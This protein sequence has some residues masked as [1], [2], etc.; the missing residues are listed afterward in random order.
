MAGLAHNRVESPLKFK[1]FLEDV[2]TLNQRA[3]QQVF[4]ITKLSFMALG[5]VRETYALL[6]S[7]AALGRGCGPLIVA[8]P[9]RTLEELA[10]SI[11]AT[12]GALTTAT[13]LL[14]LYLQKVPRVEHMVFSDIM[15]AVAAGRFD[16]GV[17][18]HEGRFTYREYRLSAVLDLGEWWENET[19]CP[20]PLGGIA[21]RRTLGSD[22][23]RL[24]DQA[25]KKSLMLASQERRATMTYVLEHAQEMDIEVVERHIQLY[26]NDF[27][28]DLGSEG[29]D[30]INTLFTCAEAA[31]LIPQSNTELMA[32]P[33]PKT[34]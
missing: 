10:Q 29:L 7:G 12:P 6:Y 27:T 21:I 8:R 34:A 11:I 9:G 31:N 32:Y 16:F 26:V 17:V 25:I 20:I 1:P 18:I 14:G 30:A 3:L 2:E 4:D 5:W 15:P 19:G 23:A 24:V 13:L 33:P 28:H 22:V